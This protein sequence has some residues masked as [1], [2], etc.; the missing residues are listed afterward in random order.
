MMIMITTTT[1]TT[2]HHYAEKA[3]FKLADISPILSLTV[4]NTPSLSWIIY[5]SDI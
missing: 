4:P 5:L 1:T 2:T 3:G